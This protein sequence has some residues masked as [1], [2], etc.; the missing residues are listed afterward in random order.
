MAYFPELIIPSVNPAATLNPN[1]NN[2]GS[3]KYAGKLYYIG[4]EQDGLGIN[5]FASVWK[6]LDGGQTWIRLDQANEPS[7]PIP[8]P[9]D[10][11]SAVFDGVQTVNVVLG[12]AGAALPV[13]LIDFDLLTETWGLPYGTVGAPAPLLIAL[14]RRPNGDLILLGMDGSLPN[15]QWAAWVF[16]G[17]VW[18]ALIDMTVNVLLVPGYD[19][20]GFNVGIRAVMAPDGTLHMWSAIVQIDHDPTWAYR[21]FYW[22]LTPGNL[23]AQFFTDPNTLSPFPY[24]AV[25]ALGSPILHGNFALLPVV[26]GIFGTPNSYSSVYVGTPIAT[27]AWSVLGPPGVD[28]AS[29]GVFNPSSFTDT[30]PILQSDGVNLFYA[31]LQD[32]DPT[33]TYFQN[34]LRFAQTVA[35]PFAGWSAQ[36]IF[37]FLTDPAPPGFVFPGQFMQFAT[38]NLGSFLFTVTALLPGFVTAPYFLFLPFPIAVLGGIVILKGVK[39]VPKCSDTPSLQPAPVSKPVKMAF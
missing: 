28:P 2:M 30:V 9:H 33:F 21:L 6:S 16:S 25:Q 26:R 11:I 34:Q 32:T 37:D 35:G 27:P 36:T 38:F 13:F 39:R 14:H 17:G 31:F 19:G 1:Y 22:Q 10:G 8:A 4:Q 20:S 23:V 7:T 15:P 12:A 18:S 29:Y 3:F 24:D 5:T